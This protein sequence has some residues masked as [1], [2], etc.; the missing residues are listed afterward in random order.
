MSTSIFIYTYT[1]ILFDLF[2]YAF[3]YGLFSLLRLWAVGFG[4]RVLQGFGVPEV[5]A[6]RFCSWGLGCRV[7]ALRA[8]IEHKVL[9]APLLGCC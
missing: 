3:M 5:W 6:L 1:C 9:R 2:I 4:C 7:A 8:G